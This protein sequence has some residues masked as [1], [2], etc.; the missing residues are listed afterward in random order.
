MTYIIAEMG[1]NHNGDVELGKSLIEIAAKSGANAIKIQ[2]FVTD[3]CQ[4]EHQ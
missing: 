4:E 1:V 3:Q 2:S